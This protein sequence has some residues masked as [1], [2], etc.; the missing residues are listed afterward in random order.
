MKTFGERVRDR[1][2][3]LG[4]TQGE[5]ARSAG[6]KSQSGIGNIESGRNSGSRGI[7]SLAK[8]LKV[9]PLWLEKEEGP[10]E[11]KDALDGNVSA[12]PIIGGEVPVISWVQAGNWQSVV[13]NFQ[14]GFCEETVTV[15]V[16]VRRHTYALRVHGDSMAPVFQEGDVLVIEPEMDPE[17][18]HY[19]IVKNGDDEATFKK[20]VKDGADWYLKPLNPAYPMK[21]MSEAMRIVGVVRQRISKFC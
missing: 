19:V 18:G 3:E 11:P 1:R 17:P 6:M 16:Q 21:P 13:D 14:P 12:G 10:K 7:A 8:A 4:M 5:L 15:T 20:L 2:I 9:N